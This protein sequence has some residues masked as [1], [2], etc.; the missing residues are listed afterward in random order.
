MEVGQQDSSAFYMHIKT[1]EGSVAA[2]GLRWPSEVGRSSA[3]CWF[4]S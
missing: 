1:P 2:R 4:A 3:A